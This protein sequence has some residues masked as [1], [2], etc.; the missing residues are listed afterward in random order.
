M[1]EGLPLS[2][3]R[4]GEKLF[5]KVC[6][7]P[8]C[9]LA[10]Y[11]SGSVIR[12]PKCEGQIKYAPKPK[13]ASKYHAVRSI[14]GEGRAY[15]SRLERDRSVQLQQLQA[16]GEISDLAYQQTVTLIN[17]P[18]GR[19]S[20]CTDFEYTKDG[21]THWEDSKGVGTPRWRMLRQIWSLCGPGP[22]VVS[23]RVGRKGV[24]VVET[25]CPKCPNGVVQKVET[26]GDMPDSAIHA[27]TTTT[28]RSIRG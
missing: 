28:D 19:I 7:M 6:Q 10:D 5:L 24:E 14:D 11:Y 1:R 13:R 23:K 22:L 12:C 21:I 18:L 17:T 3:I 8:K 16:A 20:L 27:E 26:L 9:G 25:I 2:K 4:G 15:P